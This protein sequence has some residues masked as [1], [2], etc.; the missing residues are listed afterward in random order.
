MNWERRPKKDQS[1]WRSSRAD[2]K[3]GRDTTNPR[4][5]KKDMNS[6][7]SRKRTFKNLTKKGGSKPT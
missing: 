6:T 7:V 1:H 5:K 4:R 2:F 3:E